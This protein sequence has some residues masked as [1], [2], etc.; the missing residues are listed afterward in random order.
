MA[1]NHKCAIIADPSSFGWNFASKLYEKIR[2]K[3]NKFELNKVD[4]KNL[5][6][7]K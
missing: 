6:I 3:T 2:D 5:G 1:N 4:I 7:K